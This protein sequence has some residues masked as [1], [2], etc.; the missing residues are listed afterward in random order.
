MNAKIGFLHIWDALPKDIKVYVLM[1][2]E[3]SIKY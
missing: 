2:I 3:K 1:E